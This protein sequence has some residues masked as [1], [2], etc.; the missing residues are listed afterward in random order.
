MGKKVNYLQIKV[1]FKIMIIIK[2]KVINK[3]MLMK[4]RTVKISNKM[5][6]IKIFGNVCVI[7]N[8]VFVFKKLFC[9]LLVSK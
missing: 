8:I 4:I 2:M 5:I 7:I 1:V 6:K 9:G 3:K